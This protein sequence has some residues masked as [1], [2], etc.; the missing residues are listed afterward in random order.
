M[1]RQLASLIAPVGHEQ[2]CHA[3]QGRGNDEKG[4][5]AHA[6]RCKARIGGM[7]ASAGLVTSPPSAAVR[8]GSLKQAGVL[9]RQRAGSRRMLRR[10]PSPARLPP[11]YRPVAGIPVARQNL[12]APPQRD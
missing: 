9:V 3:S 4:R 5:D 8:R 2:R 1:S 12:L 6:C 11:L 7:P 10:R